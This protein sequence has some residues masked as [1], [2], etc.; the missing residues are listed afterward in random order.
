M[1]AHPEADD[2]ARVGKYYYYCFIIISIIFTVWRLDSYNSS[3]NQNFHVSSLNSITQLTWTIFELHFEFRFNSIIIKTNSSST[4]CWW[5][6]SDHAINSSTYTSTTKISTI[7]IPR[8]NHTISNSHMQP[9]H[10]KPVVHI[11]FQHSETP[12]QK[13]FPAIPR[14]FINSG[15]GNNNRS[16][17]FTSPD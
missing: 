13:V 6:I 17:I 16:T 15:H 14:A 5:K 1:D 12:N 7:T 8:I 4:V 11:T 2:D 9:K 3:L 10:S